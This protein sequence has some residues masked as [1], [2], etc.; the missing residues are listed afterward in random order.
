MLKD[1]DFLFLMM[2][3]ALSINRLLV[4]MLYATSIFAYSQQFTD[5]HIVTKWIFVGIIICI[6]GLYNSVLVTNSYGYLKENILLLESMILLCLLQAIYGILQYLGLFSSHSLHEITGSFDNPAGFAACLCAGLPFVGF[7]LSNDSKY[8][9]CAGWIVGIIMVMAVILSGS[10]AGIVSIAVAVV[11]FLFQRLDRR[12][13]VWKYVLLV[14]TIPLFIACYWAKKNSADGRLLI[15]QCS[16]NMLKDAPLL[17]HGIGS[18]EACYMDYQAKYFK[19]HGANR[20]TMLADNVK[21][22]FNEYLCV[23]LNF[24]I[25]GLL[26]LL[27]FVLFLAWCYGRKTDKEKRIAAYVLLSIGIFSL[28]SYPF[29]YPFTWIVTFICIYFIIKDRIKNFLVMSGVKDIICIIVFIGSFWCIYKFIDRIQTEI[30]WTEVSELSLVGKY[31]EALPGYKVLEDKLTNDPYFLYNYA[32][33]LLKAK[34]YEESLEIALRC[35]RYW[36]D[37][38]LELI[39][40]ENYQWLKQP[41]HAALYYNSAALMCPSRFLPHYKLFF[42][43]K[44]NDEKKRMIEVAETIIRKPIKIKT[45]AI[46]MM[47]KE[48][49]KEKLQVMSKLMNIS[50]TDEEY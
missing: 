43:Y 15:W 18:F 28:F 36:A 25:I 4:F 45:P 5:A 40:G 41:E 7:L 21:H 3:L 19:T 1:V 10:R 26:I 13:Y 37:Y 22:P 6:I 50:D 38:D 12:R 16:I 20:Y 39:I 9:R 29:M 17:G 48:M 2:R 31:E 44:E 27:M 33:I 32:A 11:V 46:L 23:L 34:Q 24:G 42:L 49:K 14:S 35:R 30:A 47:K 8:I